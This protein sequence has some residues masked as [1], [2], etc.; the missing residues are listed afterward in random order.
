MSVLDWNK[1]YKPAPFPKTEEERLAAAK[2][3]NVLPEEYKPYADDGLGYGDYP[4]LPNVSV[5]TRD[6]NYPY[7]F[8]EHKR[9]FHEPV[10]E[11]HILYSVRNRSPNLHLNSFLDPC[12]HRY[13]R[14]GQ[15]RLGTVAFS[16][17]IP[18]SSI[19]SRYGRVFQSVL[20]AGRQAYVPAGV[21]QTVPR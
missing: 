20:L 14:R 16:V 15:I 21:S 13:V 3:Y 12:R 4:K 9:N 10:R 1:D 17:E 7:D 8:P 6:P 18:V 2:K 19:C 5:E 11:L